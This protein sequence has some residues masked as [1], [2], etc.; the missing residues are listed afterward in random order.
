MRILISLVC[1]VLVTLVLFFLMMGFIRRDALPV[2]DVEPEVLV[3][4]E[5]IDQG[6]EQKK[7]HKAKKMQMP[8]QAA[9]E[10]NP[11]LSEQMNL[12]VPVV[13]ISLDLTIESDLLNL[14][15]FPVL[16]KNW[17]QPSQLSSQ[18]G[19]EG[20]DDQFKSAPKSIRKITPVST[21]MPQIPKV[22]WDNKINGWVLLSFTVTTAGLVTD[23]RILDASP[24]GV[25]EEYAVLAAK[26]WRYAHMEQ[27][28]YVSQKIEF[29]WENYPY[30]WD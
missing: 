8:E 26:Q 30:N 1:A 13:D 29:F 7:A 5:Q 19:S 18:A 4:I 17:V 25:F 28:R 27:A 14:E 24:R 22:A 6:Q 23:I 11:Q 12:T 3:N 15:A 16:Q 2:F 10:L 20:L 9:P 21:R